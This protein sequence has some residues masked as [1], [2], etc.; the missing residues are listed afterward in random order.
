MLSYIRENLTKTLA[1]LSLVSI[2]TGSVFIW[3]GYKTMKE[4]DTDFPKRTG[5]LEKIEEIDNQIRNSHREKFTLDVKSL[6]EE[7]K[8][9]IESVGGKLKYDGLLDKFRAKERDYRDEKEK[10]R[11]TMDLGFY[12]SGWGFLPG[13]LSIAYGHYESQL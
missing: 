5:I 10:G 4:C 3:G 12:L 2:L 8:K 1:T 11:R 13:I 7:R 6:I 9:I